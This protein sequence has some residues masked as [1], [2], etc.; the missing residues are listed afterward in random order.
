[1]R[2]IASEMKHCVICMKQHEVDTVEVMD[3]E[4]FK[5]EEVSFRA[6]YEY[7][8]NTDEY[9]ETEDMIRQNSLAMKD[10][11]RQK[12]GLLTSREIEAIRRKYLISQKDLSEVLNWGKATITRYENHQVQDWVHDDVLRK[13]DFDPKWF[14]EMV[15]RAKERLPEKAYTKY[16]RVAKEIYKQNKNRYLIDAIYA[17]YATFNEPFTGGVQLNLNKV[18]EMIN[19]LAAK[20]RSL[21]KVK[22]MKMLWYSDALYYKRTGR[23]ISGLVYLAMPLGAVPEAHDQIISLDGVFYDEVNYGD[24]FGYRFRPDP[25]FTITE[26]TE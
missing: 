5:D 20:V 25:Y 17:A 23:A 1:M 8:S 2:K 12:V 4:I 11:Y 9:L 24:Y 6:I 22:L 15:S 10:A 19:Y 16:I 7:C 13:I 18:R 26:L 14:L 21:H 3:T